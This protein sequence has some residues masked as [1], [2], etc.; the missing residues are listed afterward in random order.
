MNQGLFSSERRRWPIILRLNLALH[1]WLGVSR[2]AQD[3]WGRPEYIKNI[4]D[5]IKNI[6]LDA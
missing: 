2:M 4:G 6:C 3:E 1:T 5:E